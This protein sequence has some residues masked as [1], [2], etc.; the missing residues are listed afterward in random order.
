MTELVAL[1]RKELVQALRNRPMLFM[2]VMAP[3]VQIILF[4]YAAQLEFRRADTVAV[5]QD[6][7]AESR[8]FLDGLGAERTFRVRA[9]PDVAAASAALR[10]GE[11]QVAVIVPRGFGA[12][13][14][15]GCATSVQVPTTARTR[16]RHRRERRY[17]VVRGDLDRPAP[18][19]AWVP[20]ADRARAAPALQPGAVEPALL[21]ARHRRVDPGDH[22]DDGHRDGAGSR[23]RGRHLEQLLVT[24]IGLMTLML[25]KMIPYALFGLLD[26]TLIPVIGNLVRRCRSTAIRSPSPSRPPA[27]SVDA[28]GRA[29][30]AA[31]ARTQQQAF[32]GA[33][34]LLPAI[35]LSG[36]MRP[37]SRRCLR[38]C[39]RSPGEPD[40]PLHRGDPLD[41]APRRRLHRRR[42]P[43]RRALRD[44]PGAARARRAEVPSQGGVT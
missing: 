4:G 10:D 11:A 12:D 22:H 34:F 41:P 38:G 3:M 8:A 17:R 44:R 25:G 9:V 20:T 35:L 39:S 6:R 33:F 2:I 13:R 43:D 16:P 32:M 21:R 18:G 36:F 19:L 31:T 30:I 14:G 1:I 28:V 7:S 24:P 40:A 26:Q 27:T 42:S 37:R 29:L 5:D 23:A 15:A